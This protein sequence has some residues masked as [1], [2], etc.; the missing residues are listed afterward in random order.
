MAGGLRQE[1]ENED[2]PNKFRQVD[3]KP[4]TH[5]ALLDLDE[6]FVKRASFYSIQKLA[7]MMTETVPI[8]EEILITPRHD[9]RST[10]ASGET[11]L[12]TQFGKENDH[13]GGYPQ[14][15]RSNE[16]DGARI[17]H[18][19]VDRLPKFKK[20]RL[21]PVVRSNASKYPVP[22]INTEVD[23]GSSEP[24]T[25]DKGGS[26]AAPVGAETSPWRSREWMEKSGSLGKESRSTSGHTVHIHSRRTSSSRSSAPPESN[27][28]RAAGIV[29]ST[30]GLADQTISHRHC[31]ACK[32]GGQRLLSGNSSELQVTVEESNNMKL[33][34][35]N[36]SCRIAHQSCCQLNEQNG[37]LV[38]GLKTQLEKPNGSVMKIHKPVRDAGGHMDTFKSFT[39]Q[40]FRAKGTDRSEVISH[41]R[42]IRELN[43]KNSESDPVAAQRD[44]VT[45]RSGHEYQKKPSSSLGAQDSFLRSTE[46]KKVKNVGPNHKR[47]SS[48]GRALQDKS[49]SQLNAQTPNS[50]QIQVQKQKQ[51]SISPLS[52]DISPKIELRGERGS[53]TYP[54][55]HHVSSESNPIPINKDGKLELYFADDVAPG[56]YLIEIEASISLS[57]PDLSGW[58]SFLIPGLLP[59]QDIDKPVLVNFRVQSISP[60][61]PTQSGKSPIEQFYC[62]WIAEA[63][64]S[65]D[66][67]YD[68]GISTPTQISGKCQLNSF[69]IIQLRLKI[70]VYNLDYWDSSNSLRTFPRW[71]E[72]LG[73]QMEHHVSLNLIGPAQ[74][75]YAQRVR[76]SFLSKNGFR[77]AAEFTMNLGECLI[78]LGNIDWQDTLT[79]HHGEV[80]VIR[81]LEDLGKPLEISFTLSY[82]KKDQLTIRLPTLSPK[83]GNA[84]SERVMLIKPLSPL[85]F[86]YPESDSFST[87][88]RMDQSDEQPQEDCF[89]RQHLPRLFPEGLKDDLVIRV[90][91]LPPVCF[92]ALQ[93]EGN[94][95]TSENP[96]NL[97]WNLKIHIDKVFGGGLECR[98]KFDIQAGSSDQVLEVSPHDW[99][100]DLFVIKRRLAT[101][102]VGEW[103]KDRNGN[104]ILFR[105]PEMTVGQ[106][107]EIALRWY[108]LIVRERLKP[109]DLEQSAVQHLLPKIVDKSILGGSL[110]C[111]VDSGVQ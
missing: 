33:D 31:E 21:F 27:F 30:L 47:I 77:N 60:R 48:F 36:K 9:S 24:T 51:T 3:T 88:R 35:G 54:A 12:N 81:H 40:I 105:L 28:P 99:T 98:M 101:P 44:E 63:Q 56:I 82:P 103:R 65:S 49:N 96:S 95:L 34:S 91:E 102:A 71:S 29:S 104:L 58:R 55:A 37:P 6:V 72:G 52:T 32:L 106:T 73:L 83:T 53:S 61:S 2:N 8:E 75:I 42:A 86:E 14:R 25:F 110:R 80:T 39:P 10:E 111:N 87:W 97:V 64:F 20:R 107:I 68:V 109:D 41:D 46:T 18:D 5:L 7:P 59:L 23:H 11:M 67:L 85:I 57:V 74:A 13:K 16:E 62:S 43:E 89:N 17:N 45:R 79:E 90:T 76:Y 66:H 26:P 92:R 93:C 108:K 38:K 84:M 69:L 50:S 1:T 4:D 100:P 78:E 22:K 15:R 94:P 70:P 19:G